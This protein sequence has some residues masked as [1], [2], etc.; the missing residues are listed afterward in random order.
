M[1]P[2]RNNREVDN[3]EQTNCG[4]NQLDTRLHQGSGAESAEVSGAH[5]S[6]GHIDLWNGTRLTISGPIGSIATIGRRFGFNSFAS[7]TPFGFSDLRQSKEILFW[8]IK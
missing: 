5:R 6:G 7:V 1:T 8:E 3:A 4:S 2:L